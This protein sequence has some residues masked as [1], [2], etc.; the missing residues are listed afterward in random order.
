MNKKLVAVAIA[1]VL[2]AP[3]AQAQTANVTLY[4]R[5]NMDLEWVSGKIIT[6]TGFIPP[7]QNGGVQ[8]AACLAGPRAQTVATCYTTNNTQFRVASNSSR[9]GLRGVESLGGGLEAFFQVESSLNPDSGSG[10]LAGRDSFIGLRGSWGTARLGRFHAPYDDT[11]GY[12]G[13]NPTWL[14]GIFGT[15]AL[16]AQAFTSKANGGFDD[17]VSNSI[18][19][20]SPIWS[21]FQMAFQYGNGGASGAEGTSGTQASNTGVYSGSVTYNNGPVGVIAA[22]QYN[23][24]FRA[25]Y[26]NDWA[27]TVAGFYQ[28]PGLRVGMAYERLDYDY[29]ANTTTGAKTSL[30]RNFWGIGVTWNLGPGQLY[31]DWSRSGDGGG[32]AVTTACSNKTAACPRIGGLAGGPDSSAN[33]WE[34]TYTYPLSKRT[35]VYT[36]YTQVNNA[37][38]AS[39]NFNVNTYPNGNTNGGPGNLAIGGKPN[40][41]AMGITHNF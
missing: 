2:A 39:Y 6:P 38:N 9:F 17:R 26:L 33:Q 23:E 15:G 34:I 28:F 27:Y 37:A 32:S 5:L 18:R 4:G 36:G 1:G 35:F 3:L 14:T 29:S 30:T 24:Q 16:W 31:A 8:P 41:F 11:N 13:N 22:F 12:W 7:S 40:G 10:T 20:D 21:G 19:W 25:R